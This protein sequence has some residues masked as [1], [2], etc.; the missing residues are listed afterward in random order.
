M[1][2][3]EAKSGEEQ[4]E[5]ILQSQCIPVPPYEF[6][7]H[8]HRKALEASNWEVSSTVTS[9]IVKIATCLDDAS[10]ALHR[11]KRLLPWTPYPLPAENFPPLL[12]IW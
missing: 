6:F 11:I 1:G 10:Q 7:R 8:V 5:V 2:K 12:R 9:S 4:K 3:G